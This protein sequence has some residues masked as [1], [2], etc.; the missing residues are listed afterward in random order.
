MQILLLAP[1]PWGCEERGPLPGVQ[2]LSP[3]PKAPAGWSRGM[4]EDAGVYS[5]ERDGV[6][7]PGARSV[8][9]DTG[10]LGNCN[11]SM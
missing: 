3:I 1:V 11:K 8:L 9:Q 4:G 6:W 10:G 7:Q 2:L 5:P